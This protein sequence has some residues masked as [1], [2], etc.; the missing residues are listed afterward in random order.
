MDVD[1]SEIKWIEVNFYGDTHRVRSTPRYSRR[2][3]VRI[4]QWIPFLRLYTVFY[5]PVI[6]IRFISNGVEFPTTQQPH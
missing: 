4:Y 3:K 5:I 6:D 1:Q 2:S